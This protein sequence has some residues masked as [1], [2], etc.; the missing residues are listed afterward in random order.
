VGS[1][2][3]WVLGTVVVSA[4][5]AAA[6]AAA[7]TTAAVAIAIVVVAA[8]VIVPTVAIAIVR[9]FV[10]TTAGYRLA[11]RVVKRDMLGRPLTQQP[12]HEGG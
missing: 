1:V 3:V 8:V 11:R 2:Q 7:A 6:A 5:A 4:A 12:V 9:I 10:A